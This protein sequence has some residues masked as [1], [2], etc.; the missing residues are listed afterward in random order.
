MSAARL[1]EPPPSRLTASVTP[2]RRS[3]RASSATSMPRLVA[4]RPSTATSTSRRPSRP[5]PSALRGCRAAASPGCAGSTWGCPPR[6][7][8]APPESAAHRL[9]PCAQSGSDSPGSGT[10][11]ACRAT[12]T[13]GRSGPERSTS[14]PP[15][16]PRA[17]MRPG[18]GPWGGMPGPTRSTTHV[19]SCPGAA[20]STTW[21]TSAAGQRAR[22]RGAGPQRSS[23]SPICPGLRAG[24]LRAETGTE[25]AGPAPGAPCTCRAASSRQRPTHAR[26]PEGVRSS[27]TDGRPPG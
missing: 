27:A 24:S 22:G 8:T 11:R 21:A 5:T 23:K 2:S 4:R 18:P 17:T 15:R 6:R 26:S 9:P 10:T 14:A 19:P 3:H 1:V 16:Q 25:A 20:C 12:R 13:P 7:M